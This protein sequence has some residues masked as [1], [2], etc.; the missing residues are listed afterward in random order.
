VTRA[1]GAEDFVTAVFAELDPAGW[2]EL[3]TCGHPPPLRLSTDGK[4][5]PLAPA[6]FTAPLGLHPDLRLSTFSVRGRAHTR[7]RPRYPAVRQPD[8]VGR[9]RP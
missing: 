5:M 2:M 9:G 6:A 1:A 8:D 4:L 7:R 3:A